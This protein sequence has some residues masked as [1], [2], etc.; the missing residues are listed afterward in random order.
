MGARSTRYLVNPMTTNSRFSTLENG[1]VLETI[2]TV[3]HID[4]DPATQAANVIF[5]GKQYMQPAAGVYVQVGTEQDNLG[6]D[7]SSRITEIVGKA[8]DTDPVTQADL[9]S[10]TIAGL[11]TLIKRYYDTAHN[12]RA[13]EQANAQLPD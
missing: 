13:E 10:V 6:L 2:A 1:I 4:Y 11:M 9:S 3:V 12:A 5:S 8:G 7:L